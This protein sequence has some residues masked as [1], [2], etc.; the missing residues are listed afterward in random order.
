MSDGCRGDLEY[1]T[2]PRLLRES[3]ARHAERCAISD[4]DSSHSLSYA[5]L[6]AEVRRAARALLARGIE[7]GDRV[8]IWGPNAAEWIIAALATHAVGGVLVPLNTRFKGGEAAYVLAKSGAR[9]LFTVTGFLGGDYL[10]SL[11]ASG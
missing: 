9:A 8:A 5:A 4:G 2:I 10:A 11:R 1:G 7:R 3:A 6:E